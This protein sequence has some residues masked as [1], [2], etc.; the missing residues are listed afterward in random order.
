[1]EVHTLKAIRYV[2]EARYNLISIRVLGEEE[3][4]IQVQEDVITVSQED[5]VILKGE[6]CRRLYKLKEKTQFEVEF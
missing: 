4:Q 5:R 6:K 2:L 3:C 1:M